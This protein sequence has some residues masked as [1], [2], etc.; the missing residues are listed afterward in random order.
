MDH[1]IKDKTKKSQGIKTGVCSSNPEA[2]ERQSA[3][4]SPEHGRRGG[5]VKQGLVQ[6]PSCLQGSHVLQDWFSTQNQRYLL[7]C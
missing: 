3:E 6:L 7:T 1:Q 4:R 5:A 2:T